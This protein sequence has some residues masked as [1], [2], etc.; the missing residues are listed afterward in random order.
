MEAGRQGSLFW[1]PNPAGSPTVPQAHGARTV[2]VREAKGMREETWRPQSPS[3]TDQR[4]ATYCI[5]QGLHSVLCSGPDR[6][7]I[8][9]RGAYVHVSWIHC[10]GDLTLTQHSRATIPQ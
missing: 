8:Q 1:G 2:G 4:M 5:T 7:E 6:E 9:N 10:A 3:A